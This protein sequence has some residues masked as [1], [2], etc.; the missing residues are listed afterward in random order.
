MKKYRYWILTASTLFIFVLWVIL[1][2]T[3]DVVHVPGVGPLGFYNLNTEVFKHTALKV[4]IDKISKITDILLYSS[5]LTVAAFG[6]VGIYQLIKRK[7]FKKVDPILYLLLGAY[8]ATVILYFVLD[9][10]KINYSPL[11]VAGDLKV[12]F[13]STHVYICSTYYIVGLITLFK[14]KN[15]KTPMK[16]ILIALV[17]CIFIVVTILRLYSGRHY[18]TDIIGSVFL[19]ATTCSAYLAFLQLLKE[20]FGK[21]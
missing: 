13:P 12:S 7:S 15:L 16:A 21:K 2:K 14:Y 8:V 19:I 11:S 9:L 1:V 4:D 20:P 10:S 6:G 17:G 3:V 5:F 18:L